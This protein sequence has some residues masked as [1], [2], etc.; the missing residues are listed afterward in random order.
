MDP[1]SLFLAGITLLA[2]VGSLLWMV[3]EG[4]A[5]RKGAQEAVPPPVET[6]R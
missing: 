5:A 3:L 2:M 6:G 1:M 4:G